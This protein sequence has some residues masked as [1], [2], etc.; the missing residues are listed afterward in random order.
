VGASLARSQNREKDDQ[1]LASDGE[2]SECWF[3]PAMQE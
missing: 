2:L 1:Q 3:A